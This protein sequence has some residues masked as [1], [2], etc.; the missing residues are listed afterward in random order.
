M[1]TKLLCNNREPSW[2]GAKA[3]R[4]LYSR[5]G[6]RGRA[7]GR[8]VEI[9]P[10]RIRRQEIGHAVVTATCGTSAER[11]TVSFSECRSD[12][13]AD[14]TTSKNERYTQIWNR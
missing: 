5:L 10:P 7:R 3:A 11:R 6:I 2:T 9:R 8:L 1:L 4:F 14:E 13:D 12:H